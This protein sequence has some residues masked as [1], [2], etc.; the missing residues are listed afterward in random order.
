MKQLNINPAE[1]GVA[2]RNYRWKVFNF[3]GAGKNPA[4]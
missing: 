1:N 2:S 3:A 4:G